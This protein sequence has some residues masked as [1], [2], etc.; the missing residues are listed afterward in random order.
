VTLFDAIF[1][2]AF[3]GVG[4]TALVSVVERKALFWHESSVVV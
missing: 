2:L 3:I 4:L 1:V